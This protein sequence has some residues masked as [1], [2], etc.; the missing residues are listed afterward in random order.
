MTHR[1]DGNASSKKSAAPLS[2]PRRVKPICFNKALNTCFNYLRG[3]QPSRRPNFVRPCWSH[4]GTIF[5]SWALLGR[6]WR[7]LL[8]LLSLLAGC[9]VSWCAP[10]AIFENFGHS[11]AGFG[12]PMALFFEVFTRTGACTARHALRAQNTIK[13][14]GKR[15]SAI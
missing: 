12:S 13:T 3:G 9:S 8:R 11:E 7:L 5:R 1:R 14:D 6:C 2:V 10:G 15:R 4:V